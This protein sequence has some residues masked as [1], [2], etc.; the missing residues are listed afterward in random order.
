MNLSYLLLK[1]QR[2]PALKPNFSL[3]HMPCAGAF[4]SGRG[5]QRQLNR[6][7]MKAYLLKKS[8]DRL[9]TYRAVLPAARVADQALLRPL[10]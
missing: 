7:M 5:R 1:A 8:L 3:Y 10:P 9:W 2:L 6:K 4:R